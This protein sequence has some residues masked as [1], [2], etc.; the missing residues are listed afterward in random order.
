MLLR[1]AYRNFFR[2][3][4]RSIISGISIMIAIMLIIFTQSYINGVMNNITDNVVK[5]ISGHIRIT[6]REYE[7]RERLFP[8]SEAIYL[9]EEFY[10]KIKHEQILYIAPRIR[11]GVLLG[12]NE[13]SLP[14]LGY[15]IEPEI[16][17]HFSA[18]PKRIIEGHYLDGSTN[19]VL[20]GRELAKQLNLSIGDTLTIITRTAYDSPT[21][22]NLIVQG[23]FSLGIGG[24]DKNIFYI[25]LKVG[26]RLLDLEG[27]ASEVA[28]IIKEPKQSLKIARE[29]RAK[30]DYAIMPYQQ[31]VILRYL[32]ST[33]AIFTIFYLIILI[34]ACSTIAN[35]MIMIVYERLREI[36]ML[37]AIGMNNWAILKL[38]LGEAGIIGF[39]G[40]LSGAILGSLLSYWLKYHGLDLSVASKTASLDIPFGPIIYFAPTPTIIITTFIFGI[41][42]TLLVSLL[43]IYRAVKLKPIEALKTTT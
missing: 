39:L 18:L 40:S 13:L 7:R 41:C 5:L 6:S 12:Q 16:E 32:N 23:I 17:K 26:E 8:L 37:K 21:G 43:P 2:N 15:A 24:M 25:P 3:T 42:V 38:L 31:N 27:R 14:C 10:Q 1:L 36:G 4:R 29:I 33:R 11:F 19:S 28:L 22:I 30:S 9:T 20:L 35:T 34:V